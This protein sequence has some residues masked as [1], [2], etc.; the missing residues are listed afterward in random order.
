MTPCEKLGYKVGDRFRVREGYI[1]N[2]YEAGD[3]VTLSWDDN[4]NNPFFTIETTGTRDRCISLYKLEKLTDDW[5]GK[6][7][8]PVGTVCEYIGTFRAREGTIACHITL[9]DGTKQAYI[10]Y[11]PGGFDAD[12]RPSKFR[13]ITSKKTEAEVMEEIFRKKGIQGLIDAGYQRKESCRG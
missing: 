2:F 3:E 11:H 12:S 5:A 9:I 1:S 8:P 10:Q 7:L 6:E 4:S 13:P